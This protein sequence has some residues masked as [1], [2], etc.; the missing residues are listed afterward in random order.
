MGIKKIQNKIG[1]IIKTLR[2]EKNLTQEDVAFSVNISRD[3]LSNIEN[4]KHPINIK[5]LYKLACFF[6]V[7]MKDFF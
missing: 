1:K 4:G 7:E 6:N 2:Q 5:T 3:H